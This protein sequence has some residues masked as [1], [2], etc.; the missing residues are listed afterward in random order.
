MFGALVGGESGAQGFVVASWTLGAFEH[1]GMGRAKSWE[2]AV[3][4]NHV[5]I[6]GFDRERRNRCFVESVE[7]VHVAGP[8]LFAGRCETATTEVD[9]DGWR[10]NGFGD[11]DWMRAVGIVVER[12]P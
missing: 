11:V 1:C 6:F 2:L 10:A 8:H 3:V 5:G 12:V 9:A 4:R 7:R